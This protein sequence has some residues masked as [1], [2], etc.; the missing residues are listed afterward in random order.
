MS[1]HHP[2]CPSAAGVKLR[3]LVSEKCLEPRECN[4]FCLR[5]LPVSCPR[6]SV[7]GHPHSIW[8]RLSCSWL[9]TEV[10]P[11]PHACLILFCTPCGAYLWS[12]VMLQCLWLLDSL[13]S[14]AGATVGQGHCCMPSV[15]TPAL[16]KRR[17]GLSFH[18]V[19]S[20]RCYSP[21]DLGDPG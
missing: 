4:S 7:G 10:T 15:W 6:H 8:E 12:E 18:C 1:C 11:D 14:R 13:S 9:E 17:A 16:T 20:D 19:T 3:E 21:T 2:H 5:A